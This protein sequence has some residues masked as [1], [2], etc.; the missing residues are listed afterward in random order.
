M[1][2]YGLVQNG[3][4]IIKYC[5]FGDDTPP[6]LAGNKGTWLPVTDSPV[7]DDV[8]LNPEFYIVTGPVIT[9][10]DTQITRVWSSA[11]QELSQVQQ[12]L[13][14]QVALYRQTYMTSGITW[15]TYPIDTTPEIVI[16]LIG[17]AVGAILAIQNGQDFEIP[18]KL[19]DGTF[20]ILNATTL[21]AM[22]VAVSLFLAGCYN[23]EGTLDAQIMALTD[24]PSCMA[25]DIT[26][27]WPSKTTEDG[28]E[29]NITHTNADGSL[30]SSV[31]MARPK[32][33]KK[34]RKMQN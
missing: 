15:D 13:I 17:A 21:F 24:V 12:N 26:Q 34:P 16:L 28:A 33:T 22:F 2:M 7:D 20:I 6:V 19:S 4:T 8:N 3:N 18:W 23:N 25:F 27:G 31:K 5:D 11:Y 29:T 9:I 14:S 30:V 1:T 32:A 10:S